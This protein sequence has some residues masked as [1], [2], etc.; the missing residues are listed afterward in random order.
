MTRRISLHRVARLPNI[1][2]SNPATAGSYEAITRGFQSEGYALGAL[3]GSLSTQAA[4]LDYAEE[5]LLVGIISPAVVLL[6]FL[7]LHR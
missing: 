4:I 2:P 6:I 1:A 5:F 7:P 3:E